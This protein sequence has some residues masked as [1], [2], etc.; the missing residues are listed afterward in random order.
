[1]Y[2]VSLLLDA[3]TYTTR[4]DHIDGFTPLLEAAKSGHDGVVS[5]LLEKG[6]D[7]DVKSDD[8]MT[9]LMLAAMSGHLSVMKTLVFAGAD[10]NARADWGGTLIHIVAEVGLDTILPWLLANGAMF[11]SVDNWGFTPL[12]YA[13]KYGHVEVARVLLDNSARIEQRTEGDWT[14][15]HLAATG[16]KR[17]SAQTVS[18][19]LDRG[20]DKE[21][22]IAGHTALCHAAV[23]GLTSNVQVLL[24]AGARV[25]NF[26]QEN[27]GVCALANAA[28]GGHV[29]TMRLLLAQ[30]ADV[31]AID[32]EG[33]SPL[34]WLC[35]QTPEQAITATTLLL[36]AGADETA[37]STIGKKNSAGSPSGRTGI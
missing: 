13:A 22:M 21:A 6:A 37:K 14:P 15:L 20:A 12:H 3:A 8:G 9:A 23:R 10:L 25:D 26:S 31:Q 34:H 11:K 33:W 30:G 2:G 16:R 29:D 28:R 36:R 19:L 18:A 32:Q 4:R 1:M 24:D 35:F 7:K 27:G 5:A 17:G